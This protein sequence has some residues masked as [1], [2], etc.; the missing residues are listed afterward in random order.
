MLDAV[1]FW[2]LE[3]LL[4]MERDNLYLSLLIC[5]LLHLHSYYLESHELIMPHQHL[6]KDRQDVRVPT[7]LVLPV[8]LSG[9]VLLLL[10]L[11]VCG[12]L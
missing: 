5:S 7:P 9:H 4:R 1:I 11:R 3:K 6:I 8:M 10:R 12:A 2:M